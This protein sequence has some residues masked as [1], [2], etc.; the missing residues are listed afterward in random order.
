MGQL[1][2]KFVINNFYSDKTLWKTDTHF[3]YVYPMTMSREEP[4]WTAVD[5]WNLRHWKTKETSLYHLL[6]SYGNWFSNTFYV[7]NNLIMTEIIFW[8]GSF[9]VFV[10]IYRS[11]VF[12][13]IDIKHLKKFKYFFHLTETYLWTWKQH[14]QFLWLQ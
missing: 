10:F 7:Y 2:Y 3:W 4:K 12:V 13:I 5:L 9:G 6:C 14:V 8:T 1:E 11:N